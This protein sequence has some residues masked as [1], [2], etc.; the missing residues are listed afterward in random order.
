MGCGAPL[1]WCLSIP[2]ARL[3]VPFAASRFTASLTGVLGT[4][5]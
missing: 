2:V 1:F 5:W 3:C 4:P